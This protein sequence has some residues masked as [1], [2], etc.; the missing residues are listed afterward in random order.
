MD[1]KLKEEDKVLSLLPRR[2]WEILSLPRPLLPAHKLL[3][4]NKL[5]FLAGAWDPA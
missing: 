3:V 2:S 5:T 1:N 4:G